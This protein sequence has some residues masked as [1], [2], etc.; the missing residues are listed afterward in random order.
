VLGFFSDRDSGA[1]ITG[2]IA[3]LG[4]YIQNNGVN[5]VYCSVSEATTQ[6]I[7]HL[8]TL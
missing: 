8:A 4:S 6:Q 3:Q 1:N 2:G 7:N 5:T